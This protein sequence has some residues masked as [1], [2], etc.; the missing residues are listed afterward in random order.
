[1]FNIKELNIFIT[2]ASLPTRSRFG[3]GRPWGI[4]M[5]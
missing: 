3:E 5:G 2:V 1:V 4:L